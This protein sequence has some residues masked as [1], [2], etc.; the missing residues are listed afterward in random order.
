M[1]IEFTRFYNDVRITVT[2]PKLPPGSIKDWQEFLLDTAKCLAGL[3]PERS[4]GV[5]WSFRPYAA[6]QEGNPDKEIRVTLYFPCAP[7]LPEERGRTLLELLI[8]GVR[9]V[10]EQ[11]SDTPWHLAVLYVDIKS[12]IDLPIEKALPSWEKIDE[13]K[14]R[15]S[16][17]P[18]GNSPLDITGYNK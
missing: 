8:H 11:Q 1:A 9:Y 16:G 13:L 5:P 4:E 18:Y 2:F 15:Y 17:N 10:Y 7:M 14:A 12:L 3:V 6:W